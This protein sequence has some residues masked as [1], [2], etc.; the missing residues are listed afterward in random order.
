MIVRFYCLFPQ[1][2]IAKHKLNN[3]R[4]RNRSY[5]CKA[6]LDIDTIMQVDSFADC[7]YNYHHYNTLGINR[8]PKHPIKLGFS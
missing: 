8:F 4:H 3:P 7:L 1:F 2:R 6:F 5:I